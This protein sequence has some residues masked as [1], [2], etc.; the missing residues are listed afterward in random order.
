MTAYNKNVPRERGHGS[1]P[2]EGREILEIPL[3][4]GTV[5]KKNFLNYLVKACAA[6]E[7]SMSH[8][9]VTRKAAESSAGNTMKKQG[10]ALGGL[11]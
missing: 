3:K 4:E 2:I 6:Y 11:S 7:Y 9:C 5:M 8:T 1:R 10:R